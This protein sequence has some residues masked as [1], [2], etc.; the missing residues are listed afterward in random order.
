MPPRDRRIPDGCEPPAPVKFGA[1]QRFEVRCGGGVGGEA[2]ALQK[3]IIVL[4]SWQEVAK[5]HFLIHVYH[6][7]GR[8][9]AQGPRGQPESRTKTDGAVLPEGE[10][11]GKSIHL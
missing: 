8:R 10:A 9:A 7:Q 6:L 3:L 2:W 5:I 11:M 1:G 4:R